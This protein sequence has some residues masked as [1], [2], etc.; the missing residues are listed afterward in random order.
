MKYLLLILLSLAC[1]ELATAQSADFIQLK[2][3]KKTVRTFFSGSNIEYLTNNGTYRNGV[4]TKIEND[5]IYIQEFVVN[6]M[7]TTFGS[8]ILDTVGSFRFVNAYKDIHAFSAPTKGFNVAG[9]GA[10]LM[11]GGILLTLGSGIVYLADKEK[12]SPGLMAASAGLAV[13]GY[14]MSKSGSKGIVIGKKGYH[15][16]YIGTK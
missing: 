15:L 9:S 8:Y 1:S 7:L 12:F 16:Q 11:G 10:A 13:A 14:F 2:K 6:R 4:I 5:S 3:N